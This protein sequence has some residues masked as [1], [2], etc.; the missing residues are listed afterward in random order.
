MD[1]K[2]GFDDWK[3][4]RNKL[5]GSGSSKYNGGENRTRLLGSVDYNNK[6]TVMN[7]INEARLLLEKSNYEL[8]YTI[9]SNGDVWLTS[10]EKDA[11]DNVAIQTDFG[12]SLEG[13]YT[14][15]NHP[16]QVTN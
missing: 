5:S 2:Y 3:N 10:G 9:T 7:K 6:T 12:V 15:H 13:A 16:E 11:V 8:Q 14:Y 4:E 1:A